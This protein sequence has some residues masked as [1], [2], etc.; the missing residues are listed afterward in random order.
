M[1]LRNA[2][3]KLKKIALKRYTIPIDINKTY[4]KITYSNKIFPNGKR[5]LVLRLLSKRNGKAYGLVYFYIKSQ[6]N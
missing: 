1:K 3:K 6:N 2:K 5:M 4:C